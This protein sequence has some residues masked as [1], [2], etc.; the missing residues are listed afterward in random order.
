MTRE[1]VPSIVFTKGGGQWLEAIAASVAMR[2]GLDWT[3]DLAEARLRTSD[4]VALQ[5]NLDPMALFA[6]P[7]SIERKL[8]VIDN[9]GHH[10]QVERSYLQWVAIG[11]SQPHACRLHVSV[12]VDTVHQVQSGVSMLCHLR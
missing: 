3:T 2:S 12:L 8:G 4:R 10:K 7:N 9:F 5:G 11:I 1:R 6:S